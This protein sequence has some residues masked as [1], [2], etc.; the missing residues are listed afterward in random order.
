MLYDLAAA[1]P[2]P[3]SLVESVFMLLTTRRRETEL[4]QTEALITAVVGAQSEDGVEVIERA[5]ASYK[6]S[7]FPFLEA[8]KGRRAELAKDALDQWTA[9][10]AL[11][12][13]PLWMQNDNRFKRL[14]SQLRRK[15]EQTKKNEAL[16]VQKRHTRI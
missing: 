1:P 4:F 13:K 8:E 6:V 9:H 5:L 11:K 10:K 14:R 12:V 7:L 15:A 3:G 16:R 2:E